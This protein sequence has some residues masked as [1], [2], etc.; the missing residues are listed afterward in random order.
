M[1]SRSALW[2]VKIG[3]SLAGSPALAA[4][5]GVLGHCRR[6]RI[7][8]APGGGPFADQVEEPQV[9]PGGNQPETWSYFG[10]HAAAAAVPETVL[11]VTVKR[12]I[13][14]FSMILF[15]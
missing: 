5:L 3:G 8:I 10:A 2:V 13:L 12:F 4:W 9:K 6:P 11:F 1:S 7:V 14:P 15:C